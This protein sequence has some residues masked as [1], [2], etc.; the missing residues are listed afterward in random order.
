MKLARLESELAA[1][2]A[3]RKSA[4]ELS[5]QRAAQLLKHKAKAE[6]LEI[7]LKDKVMRTYTNWVIYN[8]LFSFFR[9]WLLSNNNKLLTTSRVET[10]PSSRYTTS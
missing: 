3:E 5:R 8:G 9:R 1:L 2:H 6:E 10:R 4:E 7:Q